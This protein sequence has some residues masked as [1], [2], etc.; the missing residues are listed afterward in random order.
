MGDKADLDGHRGHRSIVE[1]QRK[2]M[3]G[4]SSETVSKNSEVGESQSNGEVENAI[5]R[6]QEQFRTLKDDLEAKT[7]LDIEMRH[8]IIPWL[9][10]WTGVI[11]TRYLVYKSGRTAFHNFTGKNSKRSVAIF[12][13]KFL[14][15][16]LKTER[17]RMSKGDAKLRE[18]IWL[19]VKSRSDEAIIGTDP[20]AVKAR[21]ARRLPKE[22][23]WDADAINRLRG[24]PRRPV[25]GVES[26]HL[27]TDMAASLP[28]GAGEDEETAAT[29]K[30]GDIR[31][32]APMSEKRT[33][34]STEGHQAVPD[35]TQSGPKILLRKTKL[36]ETGSPASW[37]RT[38][39]GERETEGRKDQNREKIGG[40][41]RSGD[42]DGSQEER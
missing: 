36:A 26:D 16:P 38:M 24:S 35:A 4:R 11:L 34:T 37:K 41:V 21:T 22:Q 39:K 28:P 7:G 13:E 12:G 9:V 8:P 29:R 23:R 17:L 2:V 33:S 1:V 30:S 15:M 18:G 27:P 6:F 40:G 10:E 5:K 42:K 32:N 19:G 31:R 20:G 14:Y 25:P 3:A